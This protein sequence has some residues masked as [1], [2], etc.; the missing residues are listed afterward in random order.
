MLFLRN[1]L[2]L[3]LFLTRV[4][5]G[6]AQCYFTASADSVLNGCFLAKEEVVWENTTN[7][8]ITGNSISKTAGGNNNWNA[9]ASSVNKV[10]NN[11][12][13]EFTVV[14]TNDDVRI[15]LSD[16]YSGTG[17]NAVDF[18]FDLRNN[19]TLNVREGNQDRG[20]VSNPYNV[21]DVLRIAVE[22]GAVR[23]YHNGVFK[24]VSVNAPTLPLIVHIVV[25]DEGGGANNA[26]VVNPTDGNFYAISSNDGAGPTYQWYKNTNPV[27]IDDSTYSDNTLSDGDS[28]WCTFTPGAGGC[29]AGPET[30]N[31][32]FIISNSSYVGD[33]YILP[34]S[35]DSACLKTKMPVQWDPI[36]NMYSEDNDIYKSQGANNTWDAGAYSKNRVYNNGYLEF[37]VRT[38]N[39][40]LRVGLSTNKDGMGGNAVDFAFQLQNNSVLNIRENNQD[41]GT[42]QNP[43]NIGDTL[44]IAVERG[45]VK[46]YWN[47]N[48]EY[49]SANTPTLPL[50]AHIVVHDLGGGANDA[51][52][53]NANAGEFNLVID[54]PGSNA[55]YQWQLN[56]VNV[57]QDTSWVQID[58]LGNHD[59]I[60]CNVTPDYTN[61]AAVSY[62]SGPA[63]LIESEQYDFGD[64]YVYGET[65]DSCCQEVAEKVTWE[66]ATISNVH[67]TDSSLV[68]YTSD[69]SW[70]G[71]ATSLNQV[72]NNGY[73]YT[74]VNETNQRRMI[75]LSSVKGNDSYGSIEYC[76]YLRNN[77]TI[78]IFES[79][80]NRGGFGSYNTGDT[81]KIA[82]DRNQVK[83]YRNS[84]LLRINTTAPTLPLYV[85]VS[86]FDVPGTVKDVTVVNGNTGI[87]NAVVENAG[88]DPSFQWKLN[89]INIWC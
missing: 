65:Y 1:S 77:G 37:I 23:Y 28:I 70:D 58:T 18:A 73:F 4:L 39:D 36:Q 74:I 50:Y 45:I 9:G 38:N 5:A 22:D 53:F 35:S 81:I 20:Q 56:G 47:G 43:Y 46:Y 7:M 24:W 48:L 82:V 25:H 55:S 63:V 14:T 64:F 41:R 79:G 85:D 15:G 13:V 68:K 78:V 75:G 30:T 32:I 26:F 52:I 31:K 71:A 44:R 42:I 72:Y 62:S 40:D 10:Y 57:G 51:F 67:V 80:N 29:S 54:N 11:G 19:G 2:F 49:T 33:F 34:V 60:T 17:G 86:I 6:Y 84:D 27:G 59:T 21:G 66:L 83:Y 8:T 76:V 87:F 16:T 88:T 61:C 89:G 12:Y 3:I 69:D